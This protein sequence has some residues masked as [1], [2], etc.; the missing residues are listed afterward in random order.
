MVN[1]EALK[2]ELLSAWDYQAV[3][4]L[5]VAQSKNNRFTTDISLWNQVIYKFQEKTQPKNPK[6]LEG[7]FFNQHNFSPFSPQ[8]ESFLAVMRRSG[9]LVMWIPNGGYEM[10]LEAKRDIIE[11]QGEILK[12]YKDTI[13]ELSSEINE[14]LSFNS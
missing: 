8:I 11:G 10:P 9:C 13:A 1:I 7:I 2:E 3:L 6:L 12:R 4:A 5:A 14:K